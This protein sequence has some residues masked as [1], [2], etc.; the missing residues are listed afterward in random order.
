MTSD[1]DRVTVVAPA[2]YV[3]VGLFS[4]VSGYSAKAIER[5]IEDGVWVKGSEYVIAPDGRRL[6]DLENYGRWARGERK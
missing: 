4:W 3:T 2:R 6:I 1:A 5:K